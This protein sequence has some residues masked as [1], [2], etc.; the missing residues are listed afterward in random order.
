LSQPFGKKLSFASASLSAGLLIQYFQSKAEF[1]YITELK[2]PAS[3]YAIALGI[4]ALWN[5]INDPLIGHQMDHKTTRWGRRFP[6]MVIFWLPLVISFGLLW[7]PPTKIINQHILL[8]LWLVIVL[9]AFD[10]S[11]TVVILAWAALFPEI[12]KLHQDRYI[13]SGLKQIF[14]FISVMLALII[15]PLY[16]EDG[17]IGSYRTYGWMLA[18][19]VFVNIGLSFYGSREPKENDKQIQKYSFSEGI[20]LVKSNPSFNAFLVTNLAIYFSY[21][22]VL[23]M[24]PFFR[25][26]ILRVDPSFETGVWVLSMVFGAVAVTIWWKFSKDKKPKTTFIL[27]ARLYLIFFVP[28]WFISNEVII[29]VLMGFVTLAMAGML[30]VSDLL[31]ADVVDQDHRDHGFHREGMFYGLNGFFIRFGIFLQAMSLLIVSEY[32]GFDEQSDTQNNFAQNGIK[33]QLIVLP[34]IAIS[35]ALWQISTRF[36]VEIK[37]EPLNY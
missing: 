13:I 12:Y 25:R 37:D 9:I 16:I 30:I 24:L 6:W 29:M 11:Y 19:V 17:N 8:L 35:L 18:I 20:G 1:F 23:S 31:L 7:S 4:F 15:P 21:G 14:G 22:Q 10:T 5:A 34:L 28:I 36:H 32:T 27:S 2:L 33:F 3:Y 26:Y